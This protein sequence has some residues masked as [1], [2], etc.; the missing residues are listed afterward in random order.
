MT[1]CLSY[2]I[3]IPPS[4]NNLYRNAGSRGRVKALEYTRWQQVASFA[5]PVP[6]RPL[7]EP[8]E[9]E[10]AVPVNRR[11]DIANCE[12]A[13]ID[14]LVARGVIRDDRWVDK[15]TIRRALE[16]APAAVTVISLADR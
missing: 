3:P 9:V 7:D 16:G 5:V 2:L 14:L 11:R 1:D 15:L 6:A 10:I 8:Y 4:A 13:I 12:K